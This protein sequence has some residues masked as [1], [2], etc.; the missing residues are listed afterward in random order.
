MKYRYEF[1]LCAGVFAAGVIWSKLIFPSDFWKVDNI[2]DFF[3]ILGAIATSG[4]V[5]V[6]L[7][8]M[9]S[10]KRQ[11]KAEADNELARRAVVILRKY[12]DEL[13]ET[14]RFAESAVMQISSNTWI[15]EVAEDRPYLAPYEQRLEKFYAVKSELASVELEC[16]EVWGGVFRTQFIELY[17]ID[18]SFCNFIQTYIN[19]AVRG[20]FDDRSDNDSSNS[21]EAWGL[22]GNWRLGD[23]ESARARI[24]ELLDPMRNVAKS[25]LLGLGK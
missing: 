11:A 23:Y 19:L 6:A 20:R 4:A 24:D 10:W 13:L 16:A 22:L 12:R 15:Y 25:K 14:W 9:N 7:M 5:I 2:H 17:T 3:E 8:T 1:L 21:V 18:E